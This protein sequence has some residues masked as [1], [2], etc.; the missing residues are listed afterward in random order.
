MADGSTEQS[1]PIRAGFNRAPAAPAHACECGLWDFSAAAPRLLVTLDVT[2]PNWLI[3]TR[4]EHFG[5]GNRS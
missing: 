1:P 2:V 4:L 5:T 3:V